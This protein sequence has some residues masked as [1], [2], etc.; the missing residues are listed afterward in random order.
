MEVRLR[1]EE[2][3]RWYHH[4]PYVQCVVDEGT[5]V[6]ALLELL[7]VELAEDVE[8]FVNGRQVTRD[9]RLRDGDSIVIRQRREPDG[10]VSD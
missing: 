5:T 1:I 2:P 3:V 8:F 4:L 10:A 7:G 9:A 6:G